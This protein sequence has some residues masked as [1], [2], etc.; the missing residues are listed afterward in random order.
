MKVTT[1]LI[2]LDDESEFELIEKPEMTPTQLIADVGGMAGFMLGMSVATVLAFVDTV[3]S[4][5]CY[6]LYMVF[7]IILSTF[8]KDPRKDASTSY[9]IWN[10]L[11]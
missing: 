10:R 1:I 6:S 8:R 3:L 7:Y 4:A 2:R 11:L 9:G 5:V